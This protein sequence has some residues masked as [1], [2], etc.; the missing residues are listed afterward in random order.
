MKIR[1]LFIW[2]S[3]LLSGVT[4][5]VSAQDVTLFHQADTVFVAKEA[6]VHV[7]GNVVVFGAAANLVHHGTIQ[8]YQDAG[9][10]DFELRNSGNV[11]ATG[12]FIIYNDWINNGTLLIDSGKVEMY[13]NSQHFKG[14]SISRFYNLQLTGTDIK[15]QEQH[16]RVKNELDLTQRELAVHDKIVYVD[17]PDPAAIIY[18]PAFGMEGIISTD[19]DGLICKLVIQ[20]ELNVIPTGSS[21][22]IFRHRPVKAQLLSS[23]PDTLKVTFH[24]HSPTF[25]AANAEDKDTSLCKIQE[26][27]FYTVN[28]ANSSNRYQ[29]QFAAH[30][31]TDGGYLNSAKWHGPTWKALY[32]QTEDFSE[33]DYVYIGTADIGDFVLEHFTLAHRTP[34]RPELTADTTECYVLSPTRVTSPP[35]QPW[36]EWAV[37]NSTNTAAISSGQGTSDVWIDWGTQ[38]GGIIS[39]YYQDAMNCLSPAADLVIEDVSVSADFS[40]TPHPDN[41]Y[42]GNYHF[43]NHSL[44]ADQYEWYFGDGETLFTGDREE[45]MHIY[46]TRG[47]G[48]TYGVY[49]VASNEMGCIDTAFQSITIPKIFV[50]YVPNS[51]TPDG[52]GINDV[53]FAESS[54]I[55]A[56]EMR[57]FNRWGELIFEEAGADASQVAWDGTYNGELV[58]SGTYTYL[59][60]VTPKS[61]YWEGKREVS[62]TVNVIR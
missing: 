50:F 47:E 45:F 12:D 51:F 29:L 23:G 28:S 57:I 41:Y 7:F 18:D 3:F 31:P 11:Y 2:C 21:Q 19:E 46:P 52:D 8:T 53:F 33:P 60:I 36:Y 54:D 61:N 14:D 49:L 30:T 39:V 25:V 44:D 1:V 5:T 20:N 4:G 26:E 37:T 59:F 62:G 56:I 24:H 13:G 38:I 43:A 40:Y 27:Y 15:E 32:D 35:D 16:I 58:Q 55:S 6:Q 17:N 9:Q 42:S 10:G 34:S 48:E 22:G